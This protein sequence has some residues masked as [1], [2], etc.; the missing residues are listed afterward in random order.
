MPAPLPGFVY[1]LFCAAA[2]LWAPRLRA[3]CLAALAAAWALAWREGYL[4]P[5]ALAWPA[6]LAACALLVRPGMPAACR[7]AGHALF[8][9]LAA[10]LFLHRLPG[11]HNFLAMPRAALTPDALPYAMYVNL[12]KPLAAFWVVL[13]MR[14]RLAAGTAA[15]LGAGLAGAAAAIA[16]CLGAALAME[17]VAWAPKWPD[18]AWLWLANNAL[19]TA[20]AEEALFRGYVQQRLTQRWA[21]RAWGGRAAVAVSAVLFGL[22]HIGLAHIGLAH[23]G[24][25]HAAGGW[26]WVPLATLAG[27]AYGA[28]YRRGGLAAAVLAHAGLNLA[29]FALYTY[30]A[31]AG[32]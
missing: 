1:P 12:D 9:A 20:L 10:L 19:L 27:L 6:S 15:T 13:A 23:T 31:L 18:G 32:A 22:A 26:A 4:D 16:V 28:A 21:G 14:P 8:V 24:L 29:H 5:R 2:L 11:F 17:M 7:A 30:P 25:A 3:L